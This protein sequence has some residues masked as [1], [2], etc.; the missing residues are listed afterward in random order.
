MQPLRS[1]RSP[2]GTDKS[3]PIPVLNSPDTQEKK[4]PTF[5]GTGASGI[6]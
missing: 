1:P 2:A 3:V 5:W 4:R 6:F